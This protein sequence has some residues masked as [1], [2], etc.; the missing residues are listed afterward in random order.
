MQK[1]DH[2]SERERK[3]E[4]VLGW[5]RI[6]LQQLAANLLR[7]IAGAGRPQDIVRHV[8]ALAEFIETYE[9]AAGRAPGRHELSSCLQ[10][11]YDEEL[12][13]RLNDLERERAEAVETIVAGSLQIAAS[14]LLGQA[15]QET[16]AGHKLYK[17]IR[18]MERVREQARKERR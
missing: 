16:V 9:R 11:S 7:V 17:G 15:T 8:R 1:N 14:R 4:Y 10:T 18:D 13:R 5:V 12:I 3:R 2:E 6:G